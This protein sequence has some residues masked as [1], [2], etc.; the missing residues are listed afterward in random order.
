MKLPIPWRRERL[1]IPVFW[2]GELHG[3]YNLWDCR[4][5]DVTE[6]LSLS[7]FFL[8]FLMKPQNGLYL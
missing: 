8:S 4:E 7:F 5:S 6:R 2:L 3:L 1:P